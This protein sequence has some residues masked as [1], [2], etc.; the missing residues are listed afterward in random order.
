ME[1]SKFDSIYLKLSL[2]LDQYF[3]RFYH[4]GQRYYYT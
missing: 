4:Y 2:P 1:F 3:D